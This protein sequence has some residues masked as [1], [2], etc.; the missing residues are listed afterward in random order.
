MPILV[1][2]NGVEVDLDGQGRDWMSHV[3]RPETIVESGKEQRRGF[4]GNAR[5]RQQDAGDDARQRGWQTT[6]K[7]ARARVAPS[8][9]APSRKLD[10]TSSSSSSVVRMMSG[11]IMMPSATPPA[12]AEKCPNGS[13]ATPKANMPM[14]I[15]GTPF[16]VSAAKRVDRRETCASVFGR[17]DAAQHADRNREQRIRGR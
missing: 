11:I 7:T 1:G 13:T 14:T 12:S 17:V 3:G 6:V 2:G 4:A 8:A 16:S 5:E 15:E 9:S 10:G